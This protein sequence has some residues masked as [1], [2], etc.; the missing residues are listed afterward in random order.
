M[1]SRA[2][3][4]VMFTPNITSTFSSFPVLPC[5][6]QQSSHISCITSPQHECGA[7]G[8]RPRLLHG[9][10]QHGGHRLCPSH[11]SLPHHL[12]RPTCP[13]VTPS[14]A[15]ICMGHLRG[16]TYQYF[17]FLHQTTIEEPHV[18]S[19]LSTGNKR[20]L[21]HEDD[22]DNDESYQKL[23]T[24]YKENYELLHYPEYHHFHLHPE[25]PLTPSLP[26]HHNFFLFYTVGNSSRA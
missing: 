6:F 13:V 15:I 10:V 23:I 14:K 5:C 3:C 2:T 26:R 24:V 11:G 9:S 16:Q 1:V 20:I 4:N 19:N 7:G 17:I 18:P 12:P 8:S 25:S 21:N 22:D